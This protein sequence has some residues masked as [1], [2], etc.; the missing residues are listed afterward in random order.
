MSKDI[1]SYAFSSLCV[2]IWLSTLN[3]N[4]LWAHSCLLHEYLSSVSGLVEVHRGGAD[5]EHFGV[6]STFKRCLG[7]E[8]FYWSTLVR[9][10]SLLELLLLASFLYL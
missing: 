1:S 3:L 8:V 5:F 6:F 2:C 7:T 10:Y 9:V 4:R